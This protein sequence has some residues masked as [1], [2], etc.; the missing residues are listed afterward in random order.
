MSDVY[1][2]VYDLS[3]GLVKKVSKKILGKQIDGIW[4]TS[5]VAFGTEYWFAMNGFNEKRPSPIEPNEKIYLGYTELT[6]L[7]FHNILEKQIE[8]GSFEFGDYNLF[9]HNCNSFSNDLSIKLFEKPNPAYIMDLP[10]T[11][12]TDLMNAPVI[13]H[14]FIKLYKKWLETDFNENEISTSMKYL[15]NQFNDDN[16]DDDCKSLEEVVSILTNIV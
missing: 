13:G 10:K 5:I 16:H 9:T 11:A 7:E 3:F 1:L 15:E 6:K 14:L 2:Y 12:I 8:D 4:H